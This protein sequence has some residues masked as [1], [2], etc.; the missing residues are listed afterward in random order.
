MLPVYIHPRP[1]LVAR[2][3]RLGPDEFFARWLPQTP[4]RLDYV[5][6]LSFSPAGWVVTSLRIGIEEQLVTKD[7]GPLDMLSDRGVRLVFPTAHPGTEIRLTLKWKGLANA[8]P[9]GRL[10]LVGLYV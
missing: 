2:I 4:F 10:M 3:E 1:D 6:T 9:G 8:I 5:D 7:G